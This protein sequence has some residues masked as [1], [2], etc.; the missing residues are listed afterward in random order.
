M[1]NTRSRAVEWIGWCV[2]SALGLFLLEK[3]TWSWDWMAL[4][5]SPWR[6]RRHNSSSSSAPSP[7]KIYH[8]SRSRLSW[9][10][11]ACIAQPV[12]SWWSS[13]PIDRNRCVEHLV[14]AVVR[15]QCVYVRFEACCR[16][17]CKCCG[18][19]VERSHILEFQTASRRI[20]PAWP[21]QR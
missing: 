5:S 9:E 4:A 15:R 16:I 18:Q 7:F 11:L 12:R 14:H 20:K 8:E 17:L 2:L 6:Q 10:L 21:Q 3:C 1:H 13:L 19:N